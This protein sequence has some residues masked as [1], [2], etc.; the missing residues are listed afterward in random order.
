MRFQD[1]IRSLRIEKG[2]TQR[3]FAEKIGT[4]TS[5]VANWEVGTRIPKADKLEEIADLFNVD[6][7]Y[8]LGK[9][10]KTTKIPR[11]YS[12][13]ESARISRYIDCLKNPKFRDLLEAAYDADEEDIDLVVLFL[14]RMQHR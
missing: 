10:T 3:E 7:D 9:T 4:S 11:L 13:E 12:D 14:K 6:I 8:L 2:W 5:A 1:V